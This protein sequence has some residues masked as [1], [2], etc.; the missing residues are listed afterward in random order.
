MYRKFS[1]ECFGPFALLTAIKVIALVVL[2]SISAVVSFCLLT[3]ENMQH[4]LF[5]HDP[6]IRQLI[7]HMSV[8]RGKICSMIYLNTIRQFAS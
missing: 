5:E 8:N 2:I 3:G 1:D 4:D 7:G 6:A